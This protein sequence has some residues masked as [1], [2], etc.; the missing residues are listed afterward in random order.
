MFHVYRHLRRRENDRQN[1]IS[2]KAEEE[3][4]ELEFQQKLAANKAEA[5]A[6][7]AKKRAKR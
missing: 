1:F 3:E 6:R 7:T 5:D 4:L 2:Q